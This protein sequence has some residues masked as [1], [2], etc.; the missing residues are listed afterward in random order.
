MIASFGDRR[1][2]D[3]YHGETTHRTRRLSRALIR[4]AER[5]FDMLDAAVDLRDLRS[6]PGN[7]LEVLRGDLEGL[8][9]IRVDRRWRLIFRWEDGEAH[10]VRLM[11][12]HGG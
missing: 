5:R 11:D 7:H 10:G 4:A 8:H 9:S 3:V 6:P 1:T 12:Y 2:E